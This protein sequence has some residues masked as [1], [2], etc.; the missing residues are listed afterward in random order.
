MISVSIL[1]IKEIEKLKEIDNTTCDVIHLDIMDNIF[2]PNCNEYEFDYKFNKKLDIHLMVN[3]VEKYILKYKDLN[4][5]YITFH[6]E[7]DTDINRLINMI[8]DLNIK[9]GLSIK[10]N[11]DINIIKPYLDKIDLVLIMGVEPGFGGQEFILNTVNRLNEFIN[12][13]KDNNYNYL[14]SI[15]GGLN[16]KTIDYVKES[17]IKVVGSYITKSENFQSKLNTLK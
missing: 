13:R 2:V 8:K 4:P 12:I 9:V 15:D 7:V 11:T 5:E 16:D 3:D 1:G 14:I 10:P 6:V 17:D